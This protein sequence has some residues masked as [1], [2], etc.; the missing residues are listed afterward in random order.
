MNQ[1]KG[2]NSIKLFINIIKNSAGKEI[3]FIDE[4]YL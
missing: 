2:E 4:N 1:C 3:V